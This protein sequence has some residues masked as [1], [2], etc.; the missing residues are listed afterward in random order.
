M[1][2]GRLTT[3]WRIFQGDL[4]FDLNK[5][6]LIIKVTF[7]LHNFIINEEEINFSGFNADDNGYAGFDIVPILG[8]DDTNRGF[9]PFRPPCL[10]LILIDNR[11]PTRQSSI[12]GEIEDR[13]LIQPEHNLCQNGE[14]D[15]DT[16]YTESSDLDDFSDF[17][18]ISMGD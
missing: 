8:C 5:D 14:L 18:V 6:S 10:N 12:V 13:Q 4:N 1:A 7:R 11:D 9:L 16:V 2:F 15:E 17:D 3:K